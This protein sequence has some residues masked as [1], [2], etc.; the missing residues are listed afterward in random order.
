MLLRG[1]PNSPYATLFTDNNPSPFRGEVPAYWLPLITT[2]TRHSCIHIVR[3]VGP[4]KLFEFDVTDAW[5]EFSLERKS[6]NRTFASSSSKNEEEWWRKYPWLPPSRKKPMNGA[7]SVITLANAGEKKLNGTF[8][9]DETF[10]LKSAFLNRSF[11]LAFN[12]TDYWA[13]GDGFQIS[14]TQWAFNLLGWCNKLRLWLNQV[15]GKKSL[16]LFIY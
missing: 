15:A 16:Y 1:I 10:S 6:F 7:G 3:P 2:S 5:D 8:A 4:F 9:N 14:G 11:S 12:D 13:N